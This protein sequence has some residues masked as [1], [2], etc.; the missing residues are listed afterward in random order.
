[1]REKI[2]IVIVSL[3]EYID[4][5]VIVTIYVSWLLYNEIIFVEGVV[6]NYH[7][8]YIHWNVYL[9]LL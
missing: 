7:S 4:K 1:M 3:Y 8:I 9:A 6:R 2:I 5:G